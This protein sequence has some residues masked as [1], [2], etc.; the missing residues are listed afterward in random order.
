MGAEAI[1]R[2]YARAAGAPC[3]R[4]QAPAGNMLAL[5]A[6]ALGAQCVSR[7]PAALRE[8]D[9]PSAQ[10]TKWCEAAKAD[11][12]CGW[13]KCQACA[14]CTGKTAP[15][16]P[17]LTQPAPEQRQKPQAPASTAQP[18]PKARSKS[19]PAQQPAAAAAA[20][21]EPARSPPPPPPP[22]AEHS[23]LAAVFV[24][25]FTLA[26]LMLLV[27]LVCASQMEGGGG[28]SALGGDRRDWSVP[29]TP[30]GDGPEL[31]A[32][33]PPQ[34]A[35]SAP[36]PREPPEGFRRF[37]GYFG[38]VKEEV[39]RRRQ[40]W[41]ADWEKGVTHWSKTLSAALFLMFATLFST[42]ALGA[43]VEKA[44]HRR[45]GLSELGLGFARVRVRLRVKSWG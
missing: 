11:R 9:S 22:P 6:L 43:L 34:A 39:E 45:T 29:S 41:R 19:R 8:K 3:W 26:L 30:T 31:D 36:G 21:R 2:A 13:C 35:E 14:H 44:T 1:D 15:A 18:K 33:A 10:C 28:W 20:A 17:G 38:G 24:I 12:Q 16:Q 7:A 42:V 40:F 37:P 5:Y 4:R 23:P 32:F 27:Q 25:A